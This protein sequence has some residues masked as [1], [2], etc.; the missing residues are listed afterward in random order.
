MAIG[1]QT[2]GEGRG[3]R[4][5]LILRVV[6]GPATGTV[7]EVGP[8]AIALGRGQHGAARLGGDPELSRA[9]VLIRALEDGRVQ[10]EDMKSTNGTFV[11]GVQVTRPRIV[12]VDD[13][14]WVGNTTLL[15]QR[16]GEPVPDEPPLEP[17]TPSAEAGLLSRI[18]DAADRRPKRL[19]AFVGIF[20]LIAVVVGAPVTGMLR[21]NN[22]FVPPNSESA[23]TDNSLAAASGSLPEPRTLVVI[24]PGAD[25]ST[26]QA[27]SRVL[28]IENAIRRDKAVANVIGYYNIPIGLF[29]SRDGTVT[30]LA[31]FYKKI[32]QQAQE[33]AAKRLSDR[34][35]SPP[36]VIFGG[37][38]SINPQ[39]RDQV[40][41]DL[42]L[43][44]AIGIPLLFLISILVFRGVVAAFIPI[45][46][47]IVTILGTFLVLRIINA[48][49]AINVFA[50]NIVT[51]LGLGL[52][53]D[54]SLFLV[55]RYRE[56]LAKV[57]RAK[58]DDVLYGARPDPSASGT[59]RF[60]GSESEALRRTMLTAGRTILFSA[61]TVAAAMATLIIFPIPFLYSMGIGGVVT[62]LLAVATALVVVPTVL[63]L[64]G[65]R[66]NSLAPKAWRQQA[67]RSAAEERSGPWY[68]FSRWVMRHPGAIAAV[69]AAFMI[70]IGSNF[71]RAQFTGVDA[72]V[73]PSNL[74]ARQAS[75]VLAQ[76]FPAD[77]A[78]Q[79][80][81]LIKAPASAGAQI[82]QYATRLSQIAGVESVFAPRHLSD[83]SWELNV[84]PWLGPLA[85]RTIDLVKSI[86]AGPAPFPIGV[87]GAT[88]Q[89][90][91]ERSAI[92]DRLPIA[93]AVLAITTIVILFVMT[94]SVILPLKSVVMNLL[95]LAFTLG[96]LVLI[97]QDGRFQKLLGFTSP[98]AIDVS[99][100][101]L[102]CAVAFGLSTDYAVFLL[103]R[104]Y[105]EH[106]LGAS[107]TEAVAVGLE[108][109]GRLVTQAAILFCL[110]IG[111]F[112]TSKVIFIKEVGV[113]TAAAVIIDSTIV[114]ALLVPSLMALLGEA[115]WWS[116]RPLRR[117]HNRIGLSEA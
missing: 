99:Q 36:N 38:A 71:L 101:V 14:I 11:N 25:V 76:E 111:V 57:G 107:N 78:A 56:E 61:C 5:G 15:V 47:G 28:A 13:A 35:Q 10:I 81:I 41:H 64:L 106:R 84:Q 49:L 44:E 40:R 72:Q 16:S 114:R 32:S 105:E 51:G 67:L 100:P 8:D 55:S 90:L 19:A 65:P 62:A 63:S 112:A 103:G 82:Q 42:G 52:S 33:D 30:Y 102:I 68:R 66:I 89:F 110:A 18:A 113:G 23:R 53:I 60:A 37:I 9:H 109:T 116:P 98:G 4:S 12:D 91:D 73:L 24:R 83:D 29:V 2:T 34:L 70:C 22:G 104:I 3:Q 93:I 27:R 54:Y 21:D 59:S 74:E 17:P 20:V 80:S 1:A 77:P 45:L 6:A 43:A 117:L 88:A 95:T 79:V 46:V 115:N 39:L 26:P 108:R 75:D 94:G 58:S 86:R 48:G 31:V 97:F 69:S 96:L 85:N 7:I 50:L 87:T 92:A